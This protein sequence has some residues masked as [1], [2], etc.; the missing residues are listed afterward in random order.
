MYY[1]GLSLTRTRTQIRA[2]MY[3]ETRRHTQGHTNKHT[4]THTHLNKQLTV[5]K[6]D[7]LGSCDGYVI[8]SFEGDKQK[9]RVIKNSFNPEFKEDFV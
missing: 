8:V 5:P 9:T 7:N 4:H 6:K 2:Q 1:A 3:T